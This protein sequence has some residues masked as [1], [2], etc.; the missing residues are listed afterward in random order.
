MRNRCPHQRCRYAL[1]QKPLSQAEEALSWRSGVLVFRNA[2]LADV[3]AEFNR[4]TEHQIVIL[5][6]R[7]AGM[8]IAGSFRATN[9]E[10]FVRLLEQGYPLRVEHRD[11]EILLLGQ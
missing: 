10:G 7:V 3:I 5:D 8:R 4:Y 9:A 6:P 2:T 1:Q 11:E